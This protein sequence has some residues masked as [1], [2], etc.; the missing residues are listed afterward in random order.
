M[1]V[2]LIMDAICLWIPG[3]MD[4]ARW[5]V[6]AV[7]GTE[8]GAMARASAGRGEKVQGERERDRGESNFSILA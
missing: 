2:L 7:D 4:L 3:V 5:G 6:A 8:R 1:V